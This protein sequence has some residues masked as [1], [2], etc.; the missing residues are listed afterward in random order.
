ME[1]GMTQ[2][3]APLGTRAALSDG[4]RGP[5]VGAHLF[6]ELRGFADLLAAGAAADAA[7]A[8]FRF[9]GL[10]AETCGRFPG[11]ALR[12]EGDSA[13][14]TFV[15]AGDAVACAV[16]IVDRD[17]DAESG[18]ASGRGVAAGI[19][20]EADPQSSD[21]YLAA[22]TVCAAAAPG[23]VLLTDDA[24]RLAGS[25]AK[26]GFT[27]AAPRWSR[28]PG[29]RRG[30]WIARSETSAAGRRSRPSRRIAALTAIVAI[31]VLVIAAA[32]IWPRVQPATAAYTGPIT[33]GAQLPLDVDSDS[34]A[35][36]QA[37]E[38]AIALA[39]DDANAQSGSSGPTISLRVLNGG[40]P[41]EDAFASSSMRTL[42]E[43]TSVIGVVGPAWSATGYA[44]IP[45]S[46]A[47]G[48]LQCSPSTTNPRLTKP[49]YGALDLRSAAPNRINFVR[50]IAVDDIQGP[51]AAGFVFTPSTP[52]S[53][54]LGIPATQGLGIHHA[55]VIYDTTDY[56]YRE[57]EAFRQA[58]EA[59]G[60]VVDVRALNPGAD[61]L[62][63]S[64]APLSAASDPAGAVYFG[65]DAGPGALEVKQAM[66]A[67]G[68]AALPLVSSD[69]LFDGTGGDEGSFIQQAGPLAANTYITHAA[70]P[71]VD[72]DFQTRYLRTFGSPP[73]DYAAASYACTQVIVA[74]LRDAIANGASEAG[75]REAVRAAA[76]DAAT[77]I[78]TVIGTVGFDANG[79][80]LAQYV[81]FYTVDPSAADGKG[82]W[83]VLDQQNFGPAP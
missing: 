36:G 17:R 42:V 41:G 64:L 35:F 70:I 9:T 31:A 16:Q 75:L 21:G 78:P 3:T 83:V 57:A 73:S 65:G 53:P 80:S 33:I 26:L 60:G 2:A 29:A 30:L 44:D 28:N 43:D 56:G 51:G 58:F 67:A 50:L 38:N 18:T 37:L 49:R 8:L 54:N 63:E 82:D 79:D 32:V 69:A 66:A 61:D 22:S 24:R 45:I 39:V 7:A 5:D 20:T 25:I 1:P 74:A 23:E 55:L 14:V 46:N 27:R 6:L 81:T 13:Y 10:V 48:L 15:S 40:D 71:P 62:A 59:N 52:G 11:A 47:A 12:A 72:A 68:K 76:V 19:A 4:R 34:R 77:R